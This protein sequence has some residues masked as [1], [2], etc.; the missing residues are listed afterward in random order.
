MSKNDKDKKHTEKEIE[1]NRESGEENVIGE[2]QNDDSKLKE[3]LTNMKNALL[4]KA[5][6]FENYKKRTENELSN[7]IKYAS[8]HL[9]RE[10]LP[11]YDDV[12]RSIDSIEKGETKD[13]ETL[14]TGIKH[15]QDKFKKVLKKEGLKE[16]DVLGKEFDVNLCDA[17]LQVPKEGVK[18]NTVIDVVEKGFYL[19]DKVIRHAKVLVSSE[20]PENNKGN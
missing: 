10:L 17:L 7:Y 5:A 2:N 9:I 8:E 12:N 4:R 20:A 14:K 13:F 6:E 1:I 11:V 18:P 15:I 16:I 3:E 19:K